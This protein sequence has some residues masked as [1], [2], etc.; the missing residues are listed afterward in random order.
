MHHPAT[1]R[2]QVWGLGLVVLLA[3]SSSTFAQC[4]SLTSAGGAYT[5]DFNT[6][7]NTAASTTNNLTIAGWFMTEAGGGAR[8]NEQ[9]A[10][11]T[12]A[13]GTGDT[14]SYGSAAA[15]DRALGGLQSGTLIPVF[16]ACF[17]N[18]TGVTL[19]S[20]DVAYTGE[21]WR[22]G[23]AGR[24]DQINFAYSLD[25]TDLATG[26][27]NSVAPLNFVTPVT[28]T[29]GAKDGNA[30]ANRIALSNSIGS[31]SI[32]NG[33]T[34]WIRWTDTNSSGA[35][36]GL[37]V[38][39]F[40][41]T[42]QG[43]APLPNLSIN[44]VTADEGNSGTTTFTFTVSLD[45]P[46]PADVTFDIATA[47][48]TATVADSDYNANSETGTTIATGQQTATFAV[49]VNGDNKYEPASQQFFVNVG[50]VNG[51]NI[52]S[53]G[54]AQGI[55]TINNDDAFPTLSASTADSVFEG[56]LGNNAAD[57]QYTLSNPAAE[58]TSIMVSTA[59]GTATLLD[60]DYV[61]LANAVVVIPAGQLSVNYTGATTIGD[62]NLE[63]DE[64]FTVQV[65]SYEVGLPDRAQTRAVPNPPVVTTV[66]IVNDDAEADLSVGVTDSPDP[67]VQGQNITYVVTLTNAGPSNADNTSFNFSLPTGTTFVSLVQ[68]GAWNCVTPAVGAHGTVGCS[69][70]FVRA[71]A[72]ASAKMGVGSAV[73]TIVARVDLGVTPGSVLTGELTASASTSDPNGVN[74][75]TT[76]AT[77]VVAAAVPSTPIP[78]LD[79]RALLLLALAMFTVGWMAMRR[80]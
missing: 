36:D 24:T 21:E 22:L 69:D 63:G 73:F 19:T 9:Y 31:L 53:A 26:I 39:D 59:D 13:S 10:V 20:L 2:L 56:D 7:S 74:N 16:G 43:A 76:A 64:T 37:A 14:Y 46:A 33:A 48:D 25:A 32:A 79:V 78:A 1:T 30:A 80:H 70:G 12:G 62:V 5:Q 75:A 42:P 55:G 50:N 18:N 6:L 66:T 77:T 8:D 57:I 15:A 38:D 67:V 61:Q 68:P 71:P 11:D 4:V 49:I 34:F 27:W 51:A 60:N 29:T 17:T 41:L 44:D 3:A 28:A 58:D 35:D 52:A 65:A 40:S 45:V 72:Q 54:D 47:D 23:T